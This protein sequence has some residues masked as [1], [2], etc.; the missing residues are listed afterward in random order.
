MSDTPVPDV[1]EPES[2]TA[3][4]VYAADSVL[5]GPPVSLADYQD[6]SGEFVPSQAPV[7]KEPETE[8]EP[9]SEPEANEVQE[10]FERVSSSLLLGG[11]MLVSAIA[12]IGIF[13]GKVNIQHPYG[14]RDYF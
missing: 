6:V 3:E 9:E 8:S 11:I 7:E 1:P 10:H 12:F 2:L 13:S 4:T 5:T 14:G